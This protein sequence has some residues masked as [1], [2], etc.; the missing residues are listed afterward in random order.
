GEEKMMIDDDNVAFQGPAAHFRDEAALPLLA[1]LTGAAVSPRVQLV[2]ELG[3]FGKLCKFGAVAGFRQGLP[4]GDLAIMLNFFEPREHGLVGQVVEFLPAQI[5]AASFHV[6][7]AQLARASPEELLLEK[8]NVLEEKLLLQILGAGRNND[9]LAAA[10][11]RQ[12]VSQRLAGA[13]PGF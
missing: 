6:A 2:P 1:F 4:G 13:G 12:Q 9:S 8:G 10:D 7:D 5:I 3:V 11:Y